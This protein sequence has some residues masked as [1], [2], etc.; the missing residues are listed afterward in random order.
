M[1]HLLKISTL[2]LANF[3]A[4]GA[5]SSF[6]QTISIPS[7]TVAD[8]VNANNATNNTSATATA[9]A[10]TNNINPQNQIEQKKAEEEIANLI[11]NGQQEAAIARI[12]AALLT[13]PQ[14]N[15]YFQKGVALSS[16]Q[17]IDES[18]ST[19]TKM[20]ELYPNIAEPYNNLGILYFT[21]KDYARARAAFEAAIQNNPSY[22]N[23]H[24]NLGD[25]YVKMA[26]NHYQNNAAMDVNNKV[27]S[28]KA[29]L[30]KPISMLALGARQVVMVNN[31]NTNTTQVMATKMPSKTM[32]ASTASTT[33][34]TA[35]STTKPA[36]KT[37][38]KATEK[39]V[40]TKETSK[41]VSK[42]AKPE[43]DAKT[44]NEILGV[45]NSWAKAWSKKDAD[46]YLKHY[47]EQFA[48]GM[49][50]AAWK[51]D[52]REKVLN[53]SYIKVMIN[54]PIVQGDAKQ[55]SVKFTQ[56]YESDKLKDTSN[57]VLVL[58]KKTGTWLIE[59][60]KDQKPN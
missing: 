44:K 32:N 59:S 47:S 58:S 30:L 8:I 24:D 38:E 2:V 10:P 54:D 56:T 13:D 5:T 50:F 34:S 11:K 43:V 20:T 39:V 3:I 55:A 4:F 25:L 15:L 36:V 41:E 33:N 53:K 42:D 52:R 28:S 51:A 19:F 29:E 60:E 31:S 18:I 48:S 22:T 23:A 9:A 40:T 45:V 46:M 17:R 26:A 27:A 16:M 57:K 49:P 14:P 21:K 1:K 37:T 35:N 12:D 7:T 6:A